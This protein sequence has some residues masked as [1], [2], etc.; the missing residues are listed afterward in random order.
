MSYRLRN[1]G[2]WCFI[3]IL[4]VLLPAKLFFFDLWHWIMAVKNQ[5]GFVL[6][7]PQTFALMTGEVVLLVSLIGGSVFAGVKVFRSS[8]TAR[9]AVFY[10]ILSVFAYY[11]AWPFFLELSKLLPSF[12]EAGDRR[13]YLETWIAAVAWTSVALLGWYATFPRTPPN[14]AF[15]RDAP[16]AARPSP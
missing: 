11:L 1:V 12:L 6:H 14:P 10:L 15:E 9:T 7:V 3:C 2:R 4:F 13:P 8:A 16:Q 5:S